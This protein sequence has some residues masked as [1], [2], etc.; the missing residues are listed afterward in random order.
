MLWGETKRIRNDKRNEYGN[1]HKHGNKPDNGRTHGN[2]TEPN[3]R[4]ENRD[5][6]EH[7]HGNIKGDDTTTTGN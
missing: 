3:K 4:N 6:H 2:K 5:E 7:G 1:G